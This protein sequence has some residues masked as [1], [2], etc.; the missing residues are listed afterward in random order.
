MQNDLKKTIG[1]A[2]KWSAISE[3]L[4]KLIAPVSSMILARLLTP[5]A[6]G[7]VATVNVII[8]FAD[9][10]TDAGF[11]KYLIQHDFSD[12][13][14]KYQSTTVAFWTNLGISLF[15]WIL[16]FSFR[17][18]LAVLV[19]S[20]GKGNVLAIASAVLPVTS[21]SS[22]QTALYKREFNFKTLFFVRMVGVSVP[23]FVTV[24]LAYFLRSY[25]ALIIGTLVLNIVNA[26]ILTSRSKWK[27]NL[28]F[29]I[30]KLREMLSFSM[31]TLL[32]QI[33]IWLTS[34]MGTFLV[35]VYLSTYYVGLYKTSI[36][37]VNQF[38]TLITSAVTPVLFSALSRLQDDKIE[39]KKM[40]YHFQKMV[41]IIVIPMG[42]GIF[43]YRDLI[44]SI[45]LGSQWKEATIF[46]G[47]WG[48][49]SALSVIFNNFNSEVYRALGKPKVS[50]LVQ[51]I[52]LTCLIP[53]L[54]FG[55]KQG[56]KM[57]C[58][59]QCMISFLMYLIQFTAVYIVVKIS[60]IKVIKNIYPVLIACIAMITTSVSLRF[61]CGNGVIYEIISII[62][63]IIV[64]FGVLSLFPDM[65]IIIKENAERYVQILYLKFTKK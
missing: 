59:S 52:Y 35:G 32:E 1:T 39:F 18:Y 46:I 36:S 3:L 23:I 25:W 57:L 47:M 63:C 31:W 65:K 22:I 7:V 37:T 20:P 27:P 40:F 56:F 8:S 33:S 9:M 5:E 60:F 12:E 24:P 16:I 21:F 62:I 48:F 29:D 34:Y 15:L 44:T 30:R 51:M 43:L 17:D 53:T 45:L 50:F 4:A 13:K 19:G 54:I 41:S 14:D 49:V 61:I 28:F 55:A 11:Q 26:V 2:T 10:F 64:Y 6:F 38:I 42:I 58:L